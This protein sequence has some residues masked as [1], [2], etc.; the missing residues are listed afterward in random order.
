MIAPEKKKLC[1]DTTDV[2]AVPDY[3][4]FKRIH[5]P[6]HAADSRAGMYQARVD[7]IPQTMSREQT[8][9]AVWWRPCDI[10]G[11]V[12]QKPNKEVKQFIDVE[13]GEP[14]VA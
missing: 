12:R 4:C 5:V 2:H 14:S 10:G 3:R 6:K 9:A 13:A 7:I 11:E 8:V 1:F